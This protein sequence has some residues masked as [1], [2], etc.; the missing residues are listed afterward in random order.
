MRTREAIPRG[1]RFPRGL[2]PTVL[3]GAH[4]GKRLSKLFG[5]HPEGRGRRIQGALRVATILTV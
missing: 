1:V 4:K 2:I 3:E 5:C